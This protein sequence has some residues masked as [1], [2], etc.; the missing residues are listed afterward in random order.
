MSQANV[1]IVRRAY[2]RASATLEMPLELYDARV[3]LDATDV[4]PDFGVVKGREAAQETLR[5]YWNTFDHYRVEIG[6]LI[7]A[8]ESQVVN[9]AL[10]RGRMGGS[11]ADIGNR[12]FHVWAFA[13]GKIVRLSIYG[14]RERALE[15]AGLAQ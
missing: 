11:E 5:G 13:E 9:M 4:S 7:H 8:D 1:E 2:E 3:V 14:E 6:E 15:A 12:Y 10:D